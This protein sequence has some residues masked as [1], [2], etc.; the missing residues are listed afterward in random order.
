[1]YSLAD[2]YNGNI[3]L[4]S[5]IEPDHGT[6]IIAH[7]W[8]YLIARLKAGCEQGQI[9]LGGRHFASLKGS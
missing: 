3:A 5:L 6:N 7:D 1:I 8:E 4:A 2:Q 9:E